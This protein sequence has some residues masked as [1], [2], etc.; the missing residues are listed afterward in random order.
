M[1]PASK[2]LNKNAGISRLLKI[3]MKSSFSIKHASEILLSIN[4]IA[5]LSVLNRSHPVE[6]KIQDSERLLWH[7]RRW[8]RWGQAPIHVLAVGKI[9]GNNRAFL[10]SLAAQ[11]GGGFHDVLGTFG[12]IRS[13]SYLLLPL[14]LQARLY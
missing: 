14:F 13:D 4:A 7:I 9:R 12:K 2:T 1:H 5:I 6:G 11:S 8:N 3:F 10:E